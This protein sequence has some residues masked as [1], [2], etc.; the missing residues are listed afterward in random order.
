MAAMFSGVAFLGPSMTRAGFPGMRR[1]TRKVT[2][3][4]PISTGII[5]SRRLPTYGSLFMPHLSPCCPEVERITSLPLCHVSRGADGDD[6]LF[7][8]PPLAERETVRVRP[9]GRLHG[10]G[11]H[12]AI[13]GTAACK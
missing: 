5:C 8:P 6:D 12:R 9:P 3:V 7:G 4:M 10:G 13:S 1:T 2:M 11:V